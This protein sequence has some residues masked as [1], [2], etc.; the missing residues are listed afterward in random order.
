MSFCP[1]C[2]NDYGDL[3]SPIK[4][5]LG[6]VSA[7]AYICN[8]CKSKALDSSSFKASIIHRVVDDALAELSIGQHDGNEIS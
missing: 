1:F 7:N 5:T 4:L 6:G 8:T 2:E 3:I